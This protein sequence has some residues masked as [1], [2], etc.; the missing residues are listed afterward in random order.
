LAVIG[1]AVALEDF[2][3]ADLAQCL[4]S[5]LHRVDHEFFR[6]PVDCYSFYSFTADSSW[7]E[8]S[9]HAEG[10][11]AVGNVAHFFG[12]PAP[13][14]VAVIEGGVFGALK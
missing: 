4:S 9:L 14:G 1:F 12:P 13:H 11:R 2:S 8:P 5:K 7:Q 6:R 3:F 10:V